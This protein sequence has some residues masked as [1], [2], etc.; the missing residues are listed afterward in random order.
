MLGVNTAAIRGAQGLCFATGINTATAI[1]AALLREGRVRRGY[2]GLST[3]QV[4][5]HLRVANFH[6]LPARQALFVE[7]GSPAEAAGLRA[8]GFVVAFADQPVASTADLFRLLTQEK[9]GAFQY[10]TALRHQQKLELRLTPVD[11]SA[12]PARAAAA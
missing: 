4:A 2:L 7:A 10:L 3:Q 5:L 1:L 8:G 6:R 12:G 11:G 9:I